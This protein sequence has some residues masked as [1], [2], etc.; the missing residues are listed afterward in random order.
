VGIQLYDPKRVAG[1]E[2]NLLDE[3]PI[4]LIERN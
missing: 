1:L 3:H 4:R 2:P